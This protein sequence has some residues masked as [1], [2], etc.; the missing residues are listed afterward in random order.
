MNVG[1]TTY[2][3]LSAFVPPRPEADEDEP[4]ER[5]RIPAICVAGET[6]IPLNFGSTFNNLARFPY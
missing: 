5:A 6:I 3:C 1:T 4:S 2:V